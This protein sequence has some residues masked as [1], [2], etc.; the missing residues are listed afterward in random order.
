MAACACPWMLKGIKRFRVV[1]EATPHALAR[2]V[3]GALC[4]Q[5]GIRIVGAP[6]VGSR[7]D[8]VA[9][10]FRPFETHFDALTERRFDDRGSGMSRGVRAHRRR[11]VGAEHIEQAATPR[12]GVQGRGRGR[13]DAEPEAVRVSGEAAT[14][15]VH[16]PPK[17]ESS[18][19][20]AH[21]AAVAPR[22]ALLG[23]RVAHCRLVIEDHGRPTTYESLQQTNGPHA[24]AHAVQ[25]I[26]QARAL[27]LVLVPLRLYLYCN[28]YRLIRSRQNL[29]LRAMRFLHGLSTDLGLLSVHKRQAHYRLH[30]GHG[31]HTHTLPLHHSVWIAGTRETYILCCCC[32]ALLRYNP[33]V[34]L[35][36][37]ADQ[38][39]LGPG[40]QVHGQHSGY[41]QVHCVRRF[42]RDV[43]TFVPL[44]NMVQCTS[45]LNCSGPVA[46]GTD[47][48]A[49]IA[50]CELL[51]GM[52]LFG[53][54]HLLHEASAPTIRMMP[55]P[56][57]AFTRRKRDLSTA[58]GVGVSR[59]HHDT[60]TRAD[61]RR[62]SSMR[63]LSRYRRD[64]AGGSQSTSPEL[65]KARPHDKH[66]HTLRHHSG[67]R[68]P[69]PRRAASAQARFHGGRG[70][71]R[72]EERGHRDSK[73]GRGKACASTCI[74]S[75]SHACGR[76]IRGVHEACACMRGMRVRTTRCRRVRARAPHLCKQD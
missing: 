27:H 11:G 55:T 62:R 17:S 67:R 4:T 70:E 19:A 68:Q 40:T 25:R 7:F 14:V 60:E 51:V 22:P 36:Q 48:D 74:A 43:C 1:Q 75:T 34:P 16:P 72:R 52:G 44:T 28:L 50:A 31:H 21:A 63:R 35:G 18:R 46:R 64:F 3:R 73:V 54:A 2:M 56:G 12:G 58:I 23:R 76:S 39:H 49:V 32:R 8:A 57:R 20:H 10:R 29:Q 6:E 38:C 24:T 45:H 42:P 9:R 41:P 33:T 59:W 5:G 71:G 69:R 53:T 47:S 15:L 37:S 66:T 61:K 26:A 13:G 30:G 65:R